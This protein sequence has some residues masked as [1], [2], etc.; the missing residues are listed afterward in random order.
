[1]KWKGK[2]ILDSLC[3]QWF[4]TPTTGREGKRV[5]QVFAPR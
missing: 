3:L 5:G 4:K 2:N 1:M